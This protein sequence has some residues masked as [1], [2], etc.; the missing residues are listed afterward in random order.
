MKK[1]VLGLFVSLV[2]SISLFGCGNSAESK[3]EEQQQTSQDAAGSTD[4]E[5]EEKEQEEPGHQEEEDQGVDP[6]ET[7]SAEDADQQTETSEIDEEYAEQKR[8][9]EESMNLF[10]ESKTYTIQEFCYLLQDAAEIIGVEF[11][12]DVA[13]DNTPTSKTMNLEGEKLKETYDDFVWHMIGGPA[14]NEKMDLYF[15]LSDTDTTGDFEIYVFTRIHQ[16]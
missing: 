14:G 16:E 3:Q 7:E 4:A 8:L 11:S 12:A 2:L 1:R 6:S 9:H 10:D 13:K 5:Q 15:G